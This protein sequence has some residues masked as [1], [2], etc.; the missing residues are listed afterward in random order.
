ML[1]NIKSLYFIGIGGISMSALALMLKKEGFAVCGS[2]LHMSEI[3]KSLEM[4]GVEVR[5][6]DAPDFVQK[7][8]GVVFTGAVGE[9]NAD[10]VLAKNLSKPIFSRAQI[11]GMFSRR[12]K[13]I[14]VAGTHGKTTTTGM[15]SSILLAGELDP[16]IHIGGQLKT[17]NS[18]LRIGKSDIFV[19][20][21]CEYKDAFLS[22]S[23]YV[24][25]VLNIEADHLD[26]F[27]NYDNIVSSFNKFIANTR[28]NGRI[29][30]N[31]DVCEENLNKNL[32]NKETLNK[33]KS[34]SFG[35][36]EG[37]VL[38]AKNIK[39]YLPGRFS[40]DVE[41][42][43]KK[44]GNI[45]LPCLGRHNIYNALASIGACLCFNVDFDVIKKG[46]E[47]Y[48]GVERRA[49][50]IRDKNPLIIHDYAHHHQEI[51]ASLKAIKSLAK[52]K[53]I[54]IFQPH[55]FTRTKALYNEFL[56]CFTLC[57]EVWLLPIYPAREQP[58]K[59][60]TSFNLSKDL[61]KSGQ[62]SRYFKNFDTCK[63]EIVKNKY[64]NTTFAILG[65]GD[66]EMLAKMF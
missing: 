60:V 22:L 7:C 38:R 32:L 29:I 49:Q 9:D 65:A 42:E 46:L 18:N 52:D 43:R 16:T 28:K 13:T 64:K 33:F 41:F 27:K 21:A 50:I 5:E 31:F 10:L 59:G 24:S 20:E 3:T 57:D 26:Y 12:K 62:K 23:N 53:L 30:Y 55:T 58:I 8:D 6:G 2:D 1:K 47:N 17:I 25:V 56:S 14:S 48:L 37:A 66:I 15:I 45:K 63:K 11:L 51:E 40:F 4:Q 39:E 34:I 61:I 36:K 44:L 35:F 54:C 19:T